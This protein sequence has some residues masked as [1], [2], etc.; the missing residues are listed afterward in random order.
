MVL[1]STTATG[2]RLFFVCWP[3]AIIEWL[4]QI[5]R[6]DWLDCILWTTAIPNAYPATTLTSYHALTRLKFSATSPTRK[7]LIHTIILWLSFP[8]I[9][10]KYFVHWC[11][12]DSLQFHI[13]TYN[14]CRD[15]SSYVPASA[16]VFVYSILPRDRLWMVKCSVRVTRC[17]WQSLVLCHL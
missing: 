2:G 10:I 9:N 16:N 17:N 11:D 4:R 5:I 15:R 12:K 1:C 8:C 13:F 3:M 7:R 14:T 6:F